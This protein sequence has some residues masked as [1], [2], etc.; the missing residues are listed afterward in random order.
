MMNTSSGERSN[1]CPVR[2]SA[3]LRSVMSSHTIKTTGRLLIGL[4]KHSPYC[5]TD[6]FID[7]VAELLRAKGVHGQDGA[8]RIH[9]EVHGRVV[10][11]N[12]PPLLLALPQRVLGA[13]APGDIHHGTD[14]FI[15]LRFVC[16]QGMSHNLDI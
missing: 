2:Y 5:M 12:R 9:H 4:V 16:F 11:E 1:T 13:F 14:K 3:R 10:L 8:G 15:L 6:Q 7:G